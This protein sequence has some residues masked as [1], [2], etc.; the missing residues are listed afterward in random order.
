[1][2]TKKNKKSKKKHSKSQDSLGWPKGTDSNLF[3]DKPFVALSNLSIKKNGKEVPVNVQI[4][5]YLKSMK[6]LEKSIKNLENT[7]EKSDN[8]IRNYKIMSEGRKLK[9]RYKGKVYTT[10]RAMIEAVSLYDMGKIS[11][12][13]LMESASWASN[14]ESAIRVAMMIAGI[15]PY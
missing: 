13:D 11:K 1:M 2:S 12:K 10:T 4:S 15:Y 8:L 14:P 9:R 6:L 7:I 5:D 3:L